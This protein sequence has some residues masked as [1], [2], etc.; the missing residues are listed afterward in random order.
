[1]KYRQ[2]QL[3]N[4]LTVLAEVNEQAY[5][6]AFG[7]F[8]Q[9][10]ARDETPDTAGV[11]HFL[12]H[13]VF[14]GT[15]SRSAEEVNR[16]LDQ[17]GS[18]SNAR[19]GEESTIYHA[20][21]L[22]EFQAEIVGLLSDLMRPALRDEDFETEKQVILEEIKMYSDQPP[23]GG[24]ERIMEEFFAGHPLSQ[25]VLGTA[26]SVGGLTSK[27]MHSYFQARYSPTNIALAAAGNVDF[28]KLVEQAERCCGQWEQ[29][30]S[31]RKHGAPQF[32]QG[33]VSMSQA[34]ST[35]QYLLQLSPGPSVHDELR[36]AA[37]VMT[38]M[39]GDD[40]SS[41]M[42][43][44]FLDPGLAE[45][46]GVGVQ[47]YDDCG[48]VMTFLCCEPEEAQRNL[49]RL[50][51]LQETAQRDGFTQR[52]LELAKRKIASAIIL[53]S[54]RTENRMFSVGSQWLTGRPFR[55]VTEIAQAYE[56]VTLSQ[57]HET[58]QR[59][60]FEHSMTVTVGPSSDLQPV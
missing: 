43:W 45:S 15:P 6:S 59:F 36:Y 44:E 48:T 18:N 55:S 41:R 5:T 47:E 1:M 58:L 12:E 20:S 2:Q 16:T 23:Y 49:E 34:N 33:F 10:G 52:E 31:Q 37:R 30:D 25:S 35:Q 60:P 29:I 38:A 26:K 14:K 21:V 9:T 40:G 13:M 3:D 32:R 57:V 54:E 50:K 46:A 11:S 39:F 22:P 4:G 28:D 42:Y 7:F 53:G 17:I 56:A 27:Q 19:T 51:H 8:V 24:F